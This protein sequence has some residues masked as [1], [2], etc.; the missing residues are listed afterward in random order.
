MPSRLVGTLAQFLVVFFGCLG[1]SSAYT[2]G[3]TRAQV[4]G[5]DQTENKVFYQIRFHDESSRGPEVYY[6]RLDGPKPA[7]P[8]HAQSLS[9]PDVTKPPPEAVSQLQELRQRLVPLVGLPEFELTLHVSADNA[10]KDGRWDV[11]RYKITAVVSSGLKEAVA[12]LDGFCSPRIRAEGLYQ[13]PGRSELLLVLSYIG[14]A[15][16]CEE[17]DFPIL[18]IEKERHQAPNPPPAPGG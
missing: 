6:F 14:K 17:I 2:G 18:L 16:G 1:P 11:P 3:P 4:L 12:Q 13:V 8:I 5:Y 15:Y 10:G 9:Q 7:Q